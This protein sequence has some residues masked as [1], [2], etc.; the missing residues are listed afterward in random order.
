MWIFRKEEFYAGKEKAPTLRP[1]PRHGDA[2]GAAANPGAYGPGGHFEHGGLYAENG[3]QRLCAPGGPLPGAG[4]GVPPA[5]V[6][7]QS[8]S[9]GAPCEHLRRPLP[10]RAPG[11]PKGLRRF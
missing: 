5:A 7:Q 8:Q 2:G 4:A 10:Q 11:A 1:S 9:G 6:R 3:P